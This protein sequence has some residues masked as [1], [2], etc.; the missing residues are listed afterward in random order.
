MEI[1]TGIAAAEKGKTK[2]TT[3]LAFTKKE[4][5]SQNAQNVFCRK[6]VTCK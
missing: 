3:F 1:W 4:N 6:Y 5:K 2:L